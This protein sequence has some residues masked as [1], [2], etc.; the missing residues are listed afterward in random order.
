MNIEH[1]RKHR[2]N[3]LGLLIFILVVGTSPALFDEPVDWGAVFIN[4]AVCLLVL[5]GLYFYSRV[6]S[7]IL[8]FVIFGEAF[9]TIF[10]GTMQGAERL[11]ALTFYVIAVYLLGQHL[12]ASMAYHRLR[13]EMDPDY[14]SVRWW[15]WLVGGA[16]CLSALIGVGFDLYQQ[17][18][19]TPS[20]MVVPGDSLRLE[21]VESLHEAG[22]VD[23]DE[24]VLHFYSAH[25]FSF[26]KIGS[27]LTDRR[28]IAYKDK[29]EMSIHSSPYT[30]LLDVEI[31]EEAGI[32][33]VTVLR[34]YLEEGV[35]FYVFLPNDEDSEV[36]FLDAL[37]ERIPTKKK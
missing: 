3:A 22:I 37:R 35:D 2:R 12:R 6:A 9:N 19:S 30:N 25:P 33:D 17:H 18:P 4:A 15:M 7:A 34:L 11:G 31:Y 29:G 28:I 10:L 13:K 16:A 8:I 23:D 5:C 14:K 1:V 21:V 32:S 36:V 26:V 24:E 27:V 20:V